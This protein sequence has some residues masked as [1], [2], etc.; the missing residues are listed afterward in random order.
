[1]YLMEEAL[2]CIECKDSLSLS[3]NEKEP[4]VLKIQIIYSDIGKVTE[5]DIFLNN[6]NKND[7]LEHQ[8]I[9][10]IT[11]PSIEF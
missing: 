6:L 3:Y 9:P 1:M 10:R 4:I 2:G 11:M 7:I 8:Y 5:F